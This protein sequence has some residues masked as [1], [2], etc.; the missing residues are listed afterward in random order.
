ENEGLAWTPDG[1]VV[2]VS[3][4]SGNA[5]IWVM[6][7]DGSDRKQLTTDPHRDATP[8]VSPDGRYIAFAS[9]RAGA[10]NIWLMNID[11]SNQRRLTGKSIERSPVFS[12]DSKWVYFVSW[13]TGKG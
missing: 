3:E 7:A 6:N 11:G 13:E 4:E 1:R 2:Y 9:E 8:D 12:A 10:E 5:D